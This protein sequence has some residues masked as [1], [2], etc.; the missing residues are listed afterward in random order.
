[1][2][3]KDDV[4]VIVMRKQEAEHD[5][6]IALIER[7][8]GVASSH[9]EEGDREKCCDIEDEIKAVVFPPLSRL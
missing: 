8:A 3:P 4:V 7:K 6:I 1:M 2:F 9:D 5:H